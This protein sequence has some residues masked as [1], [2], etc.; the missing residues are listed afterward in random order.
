MR[1][2]SVRRL[3]AP[4][5]R[6]AP[7]TGCR[8]PDDELPLTTETDWSEVGRPVAVVT[9]RWGDGEQSVLSAHDPM[10]DEPLPPFDRS[11]SVETAPTLDCLVERFGGETR[12]DALVAAARAY[13]TSGLDADADWWL[14]DAHGCPPTG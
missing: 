6:A 8:L 14:A 5:A 10:S 12:F 2:A 3:D 4:A 7:A 1:S 9:G 13:R 11:E